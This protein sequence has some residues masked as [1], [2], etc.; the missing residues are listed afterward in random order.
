[1]STPDSVCPPG[2]VDVAMAPAPR[3]DV[4]ALTAR[5]RG[6]LQLLTREIL[7]SAGSALYARLYPEHHGPV[8]PLRL[9]RPGATSWAGEVA[10]GDAPPGTLVATL[11]ML[12]G[13]T[14]SCMLPAD[15][16]RRPPVTGQGP[17]SSAGDV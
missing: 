17:G 6:P 5:V 11:V 7:L 12:G 15:G 4:A 3:P 13:T 16:W 2:L 9:V 10:A 1:L 8:R 14:F